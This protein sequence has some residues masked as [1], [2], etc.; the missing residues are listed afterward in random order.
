MSIISNKLKTQ[1]KQ[2]KNHSPV[3]N[4]NVKTQKYYLF[5]KSEIDLAVQQYEYLFII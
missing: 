1:C 4:N 3:I 5:L 2:H